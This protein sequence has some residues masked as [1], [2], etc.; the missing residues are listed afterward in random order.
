L[1][2][3]EIDPPVHMQAFPNHASDD[4]RRGALNLFP[5]WLHTSKAA[6]VT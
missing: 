1:L 5:Q 2:D 6:L 4:P 3:P